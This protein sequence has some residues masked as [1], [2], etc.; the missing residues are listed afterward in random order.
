MFHTLI[1]CLGFFV[2]ASTTFAAEKQSVSLKASVIYSMDRVHFST[3]EPP[4]PPLGCDYYYVKKKKVGSL[5]GKLTI[6]E[7]GQSAS[8]EFN[9]KSY[10][11]ELKSFSTIP[12]TGIFGWFHTQRPKLTFSISP[13][14]VKDV[15]TRIIEQVVFLTKFSSGAPLF[16]SQHQLLSKLNR[17]MAY[18]SQGSYEFSASYSRQ[19]SGWHST[20]QDNTITNVQFPGDDP[21][22]EDHFEFVMDVGNKVKAE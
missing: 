9:N 4:C 17:Y 2:T 18:D 14:A 11:V 3:P 16:I 21:T 15:M 5:S 20:I 8:L 10:P 22:D 7:D 1:L 12:N 19:W 6:N 13:D